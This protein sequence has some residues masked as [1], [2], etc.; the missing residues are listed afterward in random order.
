MTSS[1]VRKQ[2]GAFLIAPLIND[3]HYTTVRHPIIAGLY[4]QQ[5]QK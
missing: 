1:L 3:A 5:L 4:R 2:P